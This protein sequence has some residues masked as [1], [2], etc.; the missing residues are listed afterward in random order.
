M[1][2]LKKIK[3]LLGPVNSQE[4]FSKLYVVK[5]FNDPST[6]NNTAFNDFI[7]KHFANVRFVKHSLRC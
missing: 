6:I 3:S 5:K 1:K 7:D 4:T 2:K